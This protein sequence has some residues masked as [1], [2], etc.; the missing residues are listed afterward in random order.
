M[1]LFFK[2]QNNIIEKKLQEDNELKQISKNLASKLNKKEDELLLN[3]SDG[4]RL[5]KELKNYFEE[6]TEKNTKYGYT[7]DWILSLRENNNIN[8]KNIDLSISKNNFKKT[9][10]DNDKDNDKDKEKDQEKFNN[11]KKDKDKNLA[12]NSPNSTMKYFS[13]NINN[14][15]NNNN[16][17]A[18]T[19]ARFFPTTTSDTKLMKVF[20]NNYNDMFVSI[21]DPKK[22]LYCSN[23]FEKNRNN[24]N[25]IFEME[26]IRK[27]NTQQY[28]YIQNFIVTKSVKDKIKEM[29]L[30]NLYGNEKDINNIGD[31]NVIFIFFKYIKIYYRLK[32][33]I[34]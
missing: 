25:M 13:P 2:K 14:K 28:K 17:F 31:L 3:S 4:F 1:K 5:K 29:K 30:G 12:I 20:K 7:N 33:K 32:A 27:P 23:G 10:N 21:K 6:N 16:I 8:N 18:N 19:S 26:K 11:D 34:Y 24:N 22:S 15:V 9:N